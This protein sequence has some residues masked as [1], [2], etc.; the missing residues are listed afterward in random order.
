MDLKAWLDEMK[1]KLAER[2]RLAAEAEAAQSSAGR[3]GASTSETLTAGK[4]GYSTLASKIPIAVKTG[5][6]TPASKS[7]DTGRAESSTPA[8]K[9]PSDG[10]GSYRT[11]LG[12]QIVP[13][14][15]D[16]SD[17]M[18]KRKEVPRDDDRGKK[19]RRDQEL[20]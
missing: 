10:G 19:K 20:L 11:S 15:I 6:S 12:R 14:A 4:T 17:G 8:P 18:G 16:P 3:K 9:A 5:S 2:D 7:H 13:S 1:K